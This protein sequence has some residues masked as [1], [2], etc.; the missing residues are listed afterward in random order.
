[1]GIASLI[2]G[3]M[4]LLASWIPLFGLLWA[5]GAIV[6]V[7]LGAVATAQA[8]KGRGGNQ[9]IAVSGLTSSILALVSI[10]GFTI[11]WG[12]WVSVDIAPEAITRAE[13]DQID[14]QPADS[15]VVDRG[16]SFKT[17]ALSCESD[18]FV[19][20]L[21]VETQNPQ[22]TCVLE[23]EVTNVSTG[24]ATVNSSLQYLIVKDRSL[25]AADPEKIVALNVRA[26][27][28]S[29]IGAIVAPGGPSQNCTAIF[30]NFGT[31]L[32]AVIVRYYSAP[33]SPGVAV[34]LSAPAS[35]PESDQAESQFQP[36]EAPGNNPA[37]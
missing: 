11:F 34:S 9:G 35:H 29:C 26:S 32:D 2:L 23:F 3:I 31:R 18:G 7:V 16:L 14:S 33:D 13:F 10:A 20:S 24:S 12:N 17:L 37:P 4:A 19:S 6:G 27:G 8:N 21:G 25:V 28:G 36:Q 30:D 1:M 5:P 15:V 22:K